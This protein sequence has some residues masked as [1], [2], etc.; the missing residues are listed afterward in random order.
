MEHEVLIL[1]C[2]NSIRLGRI[3]TVENFGIGIQ[4]VLFKKDQSSNSE[5]D[6]RIE[7][8]IGVPPAF[9]ADKPHMSC[10]AGIEKLPKSLSQNGR[11]VAPWL[12][13][14]WPAGYTLTQLIKDVCTRLDESS[15]QTPTY[16]PVQPLYDIS[17]VLPTPSAPTLYSE[18]A[19][20]D[21]SRQ[22][23]LRCKWRDTIKQ[24]PI[25]TVHTLA[26]LRQ[27]IRHHIP[28][29]MQPGILLKV[30]RSSQDAVFLR[31][32][33]D[34]R[35]I[36]SSNTAVVFLLIEENNNSPAP[37]R[38]VDL[39]GLQGLSSKDPTT[40]APPAS[41][42]RLQPSSPNLVSI[43]KP[44]CTVREVAWKDLGIQKHVGT[45]SSC[46]VYKG[47]WRGAEVAVKSFTGADRKAVE[48]EF[49]NEVEMMHHLGSH[50]S[51]VLFLAVCADPLSIVF[52]YLPFSLFEL[53]NGVP[54]QKRRIPPFPT[55]WTR[56]VNMML[57]AARGL[58]FL[59]S[60]DIIHRDMKSLNLLVTA[61]G[62]VKLADF[63][64]SR[65]ANQNDLMTGCCGTFQWMAP[66]V[67]SSQRYSL[68]ADVYS[69]G[70]ILW[71]ICEGAAPFKELAPGQIPI[72]VVH[73]RRRPVLSPKTPLPLRDLIQRCWQHDPASRP[74]AAE[75]VTILQGFLP[76][77]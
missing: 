14:R 60:F 18:K 2:L 65:V 1:F 46:R 41:P 8:A 6:D 75:V 48:R 49:A 51:L 76:A 10:T 74:T 12:Q 21:D 30:L 4:L 73:E 24:F 55:S 32:D 62:R 42:A 26:E 28:A 50:P 19:G 37:V 61:E 25:S 77:A 13:G 63:G 45:G 54:D 34:I 35:Q 52:E 64:I 27:A 59:H 69:F 43:L 53:I 39:L 66:E 44:G 70:V 68:S 17:M 33:N 9:P 56:R 57:D 67:I 31:T 71:E 20:K 38:S 36:Y 15:N 40:L 16:A 11:F 72:A 29:I 23:M 58:Q 7:L 47:N 3:G 5:T 22:V